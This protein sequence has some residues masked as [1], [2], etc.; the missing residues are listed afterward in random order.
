[1]VDINL[2]SIIQM[3]KTFKILCCLGIV[4]TYSIN[5]HAQKINFKFATQ[6]EAQKLLTSEDSYT[7]GWSQIDIDMRMQKENSQKAALIRF[8]GEQALEWQENEKKRFLQFAKEI[9]DSIAALQLQ[10]P[11]PDEIILLKTTMQEEGGAGG[12]TRKNWI[13]LGKAPIESPADHL[14]R[15]LLVHELFHVITRANPDFKRK[16]YSTI[17]FN[18]LENNIEYPKDFLER[19]V[20]NPD[21]TYD[22]YATFTVNGQK[23]NC[24][25][26]IYTDKTFKGQ[27]LFECIHNIGFIPLDKQFKPKTKDG[28]TIIYPMKDIS[29]FYEKIGYNTR[30]VIHP[31]EILAENFVIAVLNRKG[32]KS[33]GL[34]LKIQ[35]ALKK[36]K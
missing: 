28:K 1:M 12:Y 22:S 14:V 18:V 34:T 7:N 24:T 16:I 31:E 10:I 36:N 32:V 29:D 8:A 35:E 11:I 26:N 20:S 13:A 5:C 2:I 21:V 15:G 19:R 27:K 30:Y 23:E 4:M 25:M 17:S 3:R 6:A 33:P 9:E